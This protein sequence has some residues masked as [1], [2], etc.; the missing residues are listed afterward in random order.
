MSSQ[1]VK[2][3]VYVW[4]PSHAAPNPS[5]IEV[6]GAIGGSW[7]V[8]KPSSTLRNVEIG[9]CHLIGSQAT[10]RVCVS[11]CRDVIGSEDMRWSQ[12]VK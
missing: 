6:S 8:Y 3:G 9:W 12:S 11:V 5:Q 4:M 7:C 2:G 10:R 1:V